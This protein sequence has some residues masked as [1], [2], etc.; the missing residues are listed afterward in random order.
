[1]KKKKLLKKIGLGI[2]IVFA[3]IQFVRIDKTNPE[4]KEGNDI[5]SILNPS[6]EIREILKANCYDCHS[7]EVVYPWYSNIAPVSW[8]VGHHV[9]EGR[10]HLN[11][12]EWGDYDA[13]RQEH[14]IEECYEEMEEHE[15]PLSGYGIMHGDMTEEDREKLEDWFKS[16]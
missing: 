14:K 13:E 8:V 2:L 10:E 16:I 9:E 15:M 1:M 6:E 11:F 12:S 5:I 7:N 3:G 4:I